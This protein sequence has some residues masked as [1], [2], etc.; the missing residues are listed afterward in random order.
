EKAKESRST[1]LD[2]TKLEE[3]RLEAMK[4]MGNL[5]EPTEIKK[6]IAIFKNKNQPQTIRA[7]ALSSIAT[8]V[9]SEESMIEEAIQAVKIAE[10]DGQIAMAALSVLQLANNT[11]PSRLEPY[12]AAYKDALRSVIAHKNKNLRAIA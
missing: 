5:T 3:E 7:L 12:K 6:A 8:F 11:A 1:F 4:Q 10:G 2:E 9:L